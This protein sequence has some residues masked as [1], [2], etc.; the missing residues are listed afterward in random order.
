MKMVLKVRTYVRSYVHLIW[1]KSGNL[2]G[3]REC[4]SSLI[5][6]MH[7]AYPLSLLTSSVSLNLF[8]YLSLTLCLTRYPFLPFLL[9]FSLFPFLSFTHSLSLYLPS[10]HTPKHTLSLSLILFLSLS[11]SRTHTHTHINPLTHTHTSTFSLSLIPSDYGSEN[12]GSFD[13]LD[14][15]A[16]LYP[17][18]QSST[19]NSG[20]IARRQSPALTPNRSEIIILFYL[21]INFFF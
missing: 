21:L 9:P 12:T 20:T 16:A 15:E 18:H 17:T 19:R 4:Y 2:R 5:R 6:M 11:L 7:F 8:L 14:N 13:S 10:S 3:S 1:V